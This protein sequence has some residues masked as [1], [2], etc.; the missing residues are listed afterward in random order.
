MSEQM[1]HVIADATGRIIA[2]S[3]V[4]P[5]SAH[6]TDAHD[7]TARVRFS[8]LKG[9]TLVVMRMP[10]E[11]HGLREESDF[12]RLVT[13]FHVPHGAKEIARKPDGAHARE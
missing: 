12:Q 3:V 10:C 2:A 4:E 8:P 5:E 1:L 13:E 11:L 6:E 7:R 9:Q